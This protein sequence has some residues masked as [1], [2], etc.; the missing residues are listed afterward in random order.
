MTGGAWSASAAARL[1]AT[2]VLAAAGAAVAAAAGLPAPWLSGS[3]IATTVASLA[4]FDTRIPIRLADLTFLI[5]GLMLGAGVSP[6]L[7]S[8]VAAWPLSLVV[9]L[10]SVV[11]CFL[12]VR[13]F[14]LH[15]AG[16]DRETAFFSA[17]PGALSYVLA[18]AS[19]T[20]ADMRRV[21]VSQSLRVFLLVALLP[22]LIAAVEPEVTEPLLAA[23]LS[24]PLEIAVLAA[25]GLAVAFLFRLIKAP[26]PLLV[27][28][29]AASAVL[30][31]SGAIAG[32]LPEPVV[33]A[34]FVVLG[35][36]VGSR[37]IGTELALLRQI[38]LA[39]IGAFLVATG[40]AAL[41]AVVLA[42]ST[43]LPV[44]QAI[45][46]FAPG[47]LDAMTAL[48]LALQMDTAYVAAHQLTR[49]VAIAL[50][51]PFLARDALKRGPGPASSGTRP[52]P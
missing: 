27:G 5:I 9:L 6:E 10:L 33:I 7:V 40:I 3:M 30:H 19:L 42:L 46:A 25:A 32:A 20:R 36:L 45:V 16:W 34:A 24:S 29:L 49:F 12:G 13:A 2:L 44:D 28:A 37:F 22:G 39:S 21:A 11:A 17:V 14:L 26:A 43:G 8:G 51:L 35:A 23:P 50:V 18:V 41:I 31:G 48:A 4:G 38:G 52:E 15:A 47:G 1:A